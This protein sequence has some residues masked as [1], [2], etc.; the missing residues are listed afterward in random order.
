MGQLSGCENTHTELNM[1]GW[2]SL[3]ALTHFER[4]IAPSACKQRYYCLPGTVFFAQ[5]SGW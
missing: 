3:Y 5:A 4:T 2:R 1:P